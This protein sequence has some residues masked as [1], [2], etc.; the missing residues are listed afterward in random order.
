M[1]QS[2]GWT[3]PELIAPKNMRFYD[4]NWQQLGAKSELKPE[5]QRITRIESKYLE[6]PDNLRHASVATKMSWMS[7][8]TTA[9][10]EDIAYSLIGLFDV[11]M[12]PM[13]GEG[14][15][16]F[17]RLQDTL[18][19]DGAFDESLFAW[20]SGVPLRCFGRHDPWLADEWGLLAPS[21]DCFAQSGNIVQ[22]N[23]DQR[24]GAG[25][26]RT[27]RGVTVQLPPNATK[28]FFGT[29]KTRI[30][31]PLTCTR[32]NRT[33][34]LELARSEGGSAVWKR[35]QCRVRLNGSPTVR[36]SN[37]RNIGIDQLLTSTVTVGQNQLKMREHDSEFYGN[38]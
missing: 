32:H 33:I 2:R 29:D 24:P 4:Q 7:G 36:V 15:K 27:N 22:G 20:S 35:I 26:Q 31:L 9:L 16:A 28:S 38:K 1:R 13:Y 3:L 30:E 23:S 21:P 11:S 5:I 25:F 34:V 14:V 12:V 37:N 19:G 6:R 18:I 17:A 10:K 8:R